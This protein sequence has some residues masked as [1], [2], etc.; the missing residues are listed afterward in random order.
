[1][2]TTPRTDGPAPTTPPGHPA[3]RMESGTPSE[4][5]DG[6]SPGGGEAD[7]AILAHL[8]EHRVVRQP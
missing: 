3:G 8:A 1:M 7:H 4:S 5:A 6:N 2:T